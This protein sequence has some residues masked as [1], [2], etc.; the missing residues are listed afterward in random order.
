MTYAAP[1]F[2]RAQFQNAN[3]GEIKEQT[4]F[5][6]DFPVMTDR[7]TFIINGTERV[8]VSQLVRS[9]GRDLPARPGCQDD[10]DR[11]RPP[12]S[13]R[14]DRV[15]RRSQAGQGHQC[16]LPGGPQAA[17]FPLHF[18]ARPGL[19][20]RGVLGA[21]RPPLPVPG[22]AV[23]AR[24]ATWP[25]PRRTP[26]SEIYK[27]ARP[28][29]PPSV[30]SARAYF[31]NAFFNSKR[32]DLTRVGRYK[33]DRKLGPEIAKIASL[34]GIELDVPV[35]GQT[36]LSKSEV[37]AA[38]TYLSAPGPGRG[39]LP[40]GRPGPFRQPAGPLGRRADPEPGPRGPLPHGA[41]RAGAH[42]DP[43]RRSHHAA[44]A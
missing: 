17:A 21:F 2:V 43:G 1:I 8:V 5:M 7:G 12:L 6:G 27:R 32:Y 16:W 24:S 14:V 44:D 20:R 25:R 10:R 4:V 41:G 40:P 23:G 34:F 37:L 31:E 39:R 26:C 42:D 15:R 38:S 13:G 33:L 35:P 30:E 36:V 19:R 9:P 18:A 28:G 29:E 11:H 22:A 3:T